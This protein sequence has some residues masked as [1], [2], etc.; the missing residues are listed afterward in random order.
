MIAHRLSTVLDADRVIVMDEGRIVEQGTPGELLAHPGGRLHELVRRQMAGRR[1]YAC[2][3]SG[4]EC[5]QGTGVRPEGVAD[6]AV[7]C[8]H[9]LGSFQPGKIQTRG[10]KGCPA[11]PAARPALRDSPQSTAPSRWGR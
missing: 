3:A 5:P 7:R 4:V 11:V 8:G 1:T 6:Q 9:D 10:P 2:S